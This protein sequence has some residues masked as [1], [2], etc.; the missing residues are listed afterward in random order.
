MLE[1]EQV[2]R[3]LN[4][5]N[6]EKTLYIIVADLVRSLVIIEAAADL[7]VQEVATDLVD[8]AA[9]ISQAEAADLLQ[10]QDQLLQEK[11]H[12]GRVPLLGLAADLRKEEGDNNIIY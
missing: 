9:L 3:L 8:L 11:V 7:Q 10:V 6:L 2:L 1:R 5:Q 12:R 4:L